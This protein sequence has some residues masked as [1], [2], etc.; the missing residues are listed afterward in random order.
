MRKLNP[1][2]AVILDAGHGGIS[3]ITKE[4]TTAPYKQYKHKTPSFHRNE[5][6]YEGVS[7][8]VLAD[9]IELILKRMHIPVFKI[10]HDYEDWPLRRRVEMANDFYQKNPWSIGLSIHHNASPKHNATGLEAFTSPGQTRADRLGQ[11]LYNSWFQLMDDAFI[12][13]TDTSDSDYDKEAK[14]FIL[15]ETDAPFVLSEN[16]FFDH[17][18]DALKIM[19]PRVQMTQALCHV[20]AVIQFMKES[21]IFV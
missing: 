12:V 15:M 4:Y 11:L 20:N 21:K 2:F 1:E 14:F 13:R 19:H 3:P 18:K 5:M 7:N 6:L 8:R 17:P 9:K 10:Y 16:G